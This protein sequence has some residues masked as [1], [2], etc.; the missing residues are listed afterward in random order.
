MKVREEDLGERIARLEREKSALN[1]RLVHYEAAASG[2]REGL[3][4]WDLIDN[5]VFV[6]SAWKEMLGIRAKETVPNNLWESL[7]HHD[8]RE[9]AIANFKD[10]I[11]GNVDHYNQEF[12]LRHRNGEYRWILSKATAIRDADDKLIRVSGSHRDITEQ[13]KAASALERSERKYRNLFQNSLVAMGTMRPDLTEI[14]EGNEKFW[15]F[16]EVPANDRETFHFRDV[17][18][19]R[20]RKDL[21]ELLKTDGAVEN[22]EL[23][24]KLANGEER[25]VLINAVVYQEEE[26]VDFVLKDITQTKENLIELQKVN[27]ELDSFVYHASHDLRSPLRSILGLIDLY[28][29]EDSEKLREECIEKIQLSVR[30]LDDLVV[31]LLSISR[32]DRVNDPHEPISLMLEINN[33]ITSYYNASDTSNLE[34]TTQIFQPIPFISDPTRVR[35]ILNNLISNA[36]KYR[37][38]YKE[39]STIDIFAEVTREKTVIRISDNGEGIESSKLPHIFDMFYRATEK[40]EGSGLGLY[41]VKKV[42]DKLEATIDVESIEL[43]GTTFTVTIP[44]SK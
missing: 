3:W 10:F 37:S 34:I 12:R 7:L 6:S 40:S 32:N 28:R 15:T 25:W 39:K 30:R 27:F 8:D 20:Q 19:K 23:Q 4:D 11:Q 44:N 33:S 17:L 14:L 16:L 2:A 21:I 1:D 41:I 29:M 18:G 31:E 36:I 9:R 26:T 13:K 22:V 38:F 35:I 42:A 43:D 5:V 24:L